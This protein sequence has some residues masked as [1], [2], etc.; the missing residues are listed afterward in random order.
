MQQ[1][2]SVIAALVG[3]SFLGC[4]LPRRLRAAGGLEEPRTS[5]GDPNLQGIYSN[6]DETGTPME[7]PDDLEGLTVIDLTAEK[8]QE[9]TGKRPRR[10]ARS[11]TVA[12]WANSISP[13]PHPIFDTFD[14]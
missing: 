12:R 10:S 6:D 14:R 13:P 1:R 11:W 8:V 4:R 5:W 7:R 2:R 9:I 3:A